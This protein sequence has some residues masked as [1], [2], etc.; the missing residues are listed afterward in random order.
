MQHLY[1]DIDKPWN[2]PNQIPFR[3]DCGKIGIPTNES[4]DA[5]KVKNGNYVYSVFESFE[6][7]AA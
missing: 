4:L 2:S 1:L 7:N 6:N 5:N 3:Q